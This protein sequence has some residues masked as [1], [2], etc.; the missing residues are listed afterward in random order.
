MNN[1]IR[2]S[3]GTKKKLL[4]ETKNCYICENPLLEDSVLDHDHFKPSFSYAKQEGYNI[5]GVSHSLCNFQYTRPKFVPIFIHNSGP[6]DAHPFILEL[7]DT[8]GLLKVIP[9]SEEKYISIMKQHGKLQFR[10]VDSYRFLPAPLNKLISLLPPDK[11][12]HTKRH[13]PQDVFDLLMRKGVYPYDYFDGWEKFEETLLPAKEHFYNSLNGEDISN[14]DYKH[15]CDVWNRFKCK[16]LADF[17]LYYGKL[18]TLQLC[19]VFQST[20][21]IFHTTYG[22]DPAWCLTLPAYSLQT[23]LYQTRI[24]IELITA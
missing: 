9:T 11:F 8:P 13:F 16:T 12:Y 24:N 20:R 10:F 7:G 1:P 3:P 18:D 4:E 23:M 22:L 15:T 2:I 17:T 6:Y 14:E 21:E 5:R 19:N